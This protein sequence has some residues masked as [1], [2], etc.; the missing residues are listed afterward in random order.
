MTI[1]CHL[2]CISRS[3]HFFRIFRKHFFH[4]EHISMYGSKLDQYQLQFSLYTLMEPEINSCVEQMAKTPG[5]LLT[6]IYINLYLY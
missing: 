3:Q 5:D 2:L 1:L 6:Y 4:P